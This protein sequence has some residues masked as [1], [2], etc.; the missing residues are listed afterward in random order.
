MAGVRRLNYHHEFHLKSQSSISINPS[1]IILSHSLLLIFSTSPSVMT[2]IL[3]ACIQEQDSRTRIKE[4]PWENSDSKAPEANLGSMLVAGKL[5]ALMQNFSTR[6]SP[7]DDLKEDV[8][9][10]A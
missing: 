10:N 3:D 6:K 8:L 9:N 2:R 5:L 1:F 4:I 7:D